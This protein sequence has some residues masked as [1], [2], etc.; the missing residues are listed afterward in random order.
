MAFVFRQIIALLVVGMVLGSCSTYLAKFRSKEALAEFKTSID[1]LA[2]EI[3]NRVRAF[4]PDDKTIAVVTFVELDNFE[5]T[6]SFGRFVSERL[7]AELYKLGFHVRELRQRNEI[8]MIHGGGEFSLTRRS[9][10]AMKKLQVSAVVVGTYTLLGDSVMVNSRILSLDTSRY[11]SVGQMET[12]IRL[13]Y[14]VM[15]LLGRGKNAPAPV[16]HVVGNRTGGHR[17]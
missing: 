15:K 2:F 11:V 7:A 13:N 12:D 5:E 4:N 17:P 14:P 9:E 1:E 8:E 3:S 10:L 6:S 16:V